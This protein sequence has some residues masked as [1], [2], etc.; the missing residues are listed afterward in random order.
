MHF[1]NTAQHEICTQWTK[2]SAYFE[3]AVTYVHN[4]FMKLIPGVRSKILY[5]CNKA[6]R[7]TTYR[8]TCKQ[9][10]NCTAYFE[11]AIS[12]ARIIIMKLTPGDGSKTFYARNK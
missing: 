4:M 10:A 11:R 9:W 12:Y 1:D 7:K 8:T 5:A 2:R 3:R 6:F